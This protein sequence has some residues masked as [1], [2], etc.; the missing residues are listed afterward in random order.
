MTLHLQATYQ[1]PGPCFTAEQKGRVYNRP[2][3]TS[4]SSPPNQPHTLVNS[5]PG[6]AGVRRRL[7][8]EVQFET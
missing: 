5:L 6:Q 2:G 7:P 1:T 3:K 4:V 8:C